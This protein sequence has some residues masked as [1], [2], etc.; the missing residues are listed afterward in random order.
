MSVRKVWEMIV[1]QNK[2]FRILANQNYIFTANKIKAQWIL[3]ST[4]TKITTNFYFP[5]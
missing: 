1:F 5:I 3:T 4:K 2:K